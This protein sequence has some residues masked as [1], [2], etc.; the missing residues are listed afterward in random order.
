MDFG[1]MLEDWD[2]IKKNEKQKKKDPQLGDYIDRYLPN[3]R[4]RLLK[5][6]ENEKKSAISIESR[7]KL[8]KMKPQREIDLHGLTVPEA[9]SRVDAFIRQCKNENLQKVLIIHGKGHHSQ[10]NPVLGKK[11]LQYIRNCPLTGEYGAAP[12]ELGGTGALW[13]IIRS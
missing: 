2:K 13:V 1:K 12:N 9:L 6:K 8:R 7:K 11:V 4:D 5:E 3:E 10:D